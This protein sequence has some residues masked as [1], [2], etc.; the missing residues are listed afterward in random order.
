MY[1]SIDGADGVGKSCIITMLKQQLFIEFKDRKWFES[2]PRI[3]ITGQPGDKRIRT[4]RALRKLCLSPGIKMSTLTN[5]LLFLADLCENISAVVRPALL[6]GNLIISDR[7]L[8]SHYAYAYAKD[9]LNPWLCQAYMHVSQGIIPDITFILRRDK[10]ASRAVLL[11]KVPDR[12]EKEGEIFQEKV[13]GFFDLAIKEANERKFYI[14]YTLH[15]YHNLYGV[16]NKEG[17]PQAAVDVI[18]RTILGAIEHDC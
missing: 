18:K 12:M 3:I 6:K 4:C 1:I 15:N 14:P 11:K 2:H 9:M 16:E 13:R 7:G 10:E 8:L 17:N 5:E